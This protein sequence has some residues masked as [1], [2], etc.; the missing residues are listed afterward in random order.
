MQNPQM[1]QIISNPQAMQAMLQ[2]QQGFQQLSNAV[3]SVRYV[4]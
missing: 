2:I 1:Q 3:P 4:G